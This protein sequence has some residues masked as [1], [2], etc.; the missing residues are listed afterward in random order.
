MSAPLYRLRR[1]VNADSLEDL[2]LERTNQFLDQPPTPVDGSDYRRSWLKNSLDK[3]LGLG[4]L[5]IA[6]VV[7]PTSL[8]II[9]FG[10]LASDVYISESRFVVRSPDKPSASG[11]GVLLKSAG[12]ANAGD[13]IFAAQDYVLSRDALQ[14][15]NKDGGFARAYSAP[16][17]SIFD[18]FN[19]LG[20]G[21]TFEDL[22][23]YYEGKVSVDHDTTSSITTLTVRAYNPHDALGFNEQL[24]EMAEATVNRLNERG[25]QDLIRFAT[26]EVNDA[27]E[28]ARGAALALSAYRN[29]EGVVDPEKQ[30]TVQLQMISKLQDELIATKTQLLQLRAFT[31]ENPQIEVLAAKVK[32]LSREADEQLGKVAGDRKSLAATAAQYQRLALE[33]QFA[34]KQLAGA[35]AS[36]QDA[37]NEARRKQAYVERIVQPN[38]PDDALEPRRYRGILA[39]FVLGLAA[40]GILTMLLAGVREHRD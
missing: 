12:F 22:Y 24:L 29:R 38:L 6:T 13:E 25:R 30:A 7:I 21:G 26:T 16:S 23:K 11:L 14:A 40:W 9:Y 15:V 1:F 2:M 17:I 18:R 28:K 19:S 36:L 39:T 35:M 31:P 5:F 32:G 8:A 3:L 37:L 4:W 20:S 33:S 27:K 10:F 34:D